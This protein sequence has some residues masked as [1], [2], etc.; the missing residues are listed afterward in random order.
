MNR[1]LLVSLGIAA[2]LVAV[3]VIKKWEPGSGVPE[4]GK[5]ATPADEIRVKAKGYSLKLV[6]SGDRW[7]I[8]EE[9]YP[10]DEG[11]V[12]D[13]E[14][15]VSGLKLLDLVSEKG[16]YDK[17]DLTEE[18]GVEVTVSAGG[19]QLRKVMIGKQGLTNSQVY[20][21]LDDSKGIYLASGITAAEFRPEVDTLRDKKIFDA[22]ADE[23]LS[24]SIRYAGREYAFVR[25]EDKKV[26][27]DVKGEGKTPAPEP[28]V[29]KCMGYESME[30][31]SEMVSNI[32]H[33]FAPLRASTFTEGPLTR[34]VICT[35]KLKTSDSA[36]ELNIYG[37]KDREM[38]Y[39]SSPSSPYTFTLGG[40]QTE[41]YFIKNIKGFKKKK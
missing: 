40:W 26:E 15:K 24:F 35:V 41:K 36:Y 27:T 29:W 21:R 16:Y 10:A 25:A 28:P 30:L 37:G 23:V 5:F 31:N 2:L 12:A 18:T 34:S 22:K 33:S 1:R 9:G 6:K 17:Y 14:K 19:R 8:N 39:A 7:L 3:I 32:L 20:V 11:L 38:Y 13:I 4:P